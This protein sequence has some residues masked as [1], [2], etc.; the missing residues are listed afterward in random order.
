VLD[1]EQFSTVKGVHLDASDSQFYSNFNIGA[2]SIPWQTEVITTAT[3]PYVIVENC[4]YVLFF[5]IKMI[6]TE[7]FRELNIFGPNDTPSPDLVVDNGDH[8]NT[9]RKRKTSFLA[10]IF[11]KAKVKA[12]ATNGGH[13]AVPGELG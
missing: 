11:Q 3:I 8:F 2:V 5:C 6:E 1:I 7:C 4:H 13:G 12:R 9:E 10:R